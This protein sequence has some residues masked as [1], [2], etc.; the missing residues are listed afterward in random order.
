MKISRRVAPAALLG[1]GILSACTVTA[2]RVGHSSETLDSVRN[3]TLVH[4]SCAG[5]RECVAIGD[6]SG[7]PVILEQGARSTRILPVPSAFNGL[8][9]LACSG[10]GNC[11]TSLDSGNGS[12]RIEAESRG[13]WGSLWKN[14]LGRNLEA[15]QTSCS[16]GGSCWTIVT[17][18]TTQ[19]PP[20][21][22][23]YA[24]GEDGGRFL[25][26]VR[27]GVLTAS[28]ART[29]VS[30]APPTLSCSS[31]RS[32]T[33]L[34]MESSLVGGVRLTVVYTQRE[35]QNHW[36]DATVIKVPP[37]F[38]VA[39]GTLA[40]SA[41]ETCV[42]GGWEASAGDRVVSGA[43]L[44][45][46]RG[47]WRVSIST[48]GHVVD[49]GRFLITD[50]S[51]DS[52]GM[53]VVGGIARQEGNGK[54]D[55]F[56]QEWNGSGWEPPFASQV[57]AFW[58]SP[59]VAVSSAS[60]QLGSKCLVVGYA[61]DSFGVIRGFEIGYVRGRWQH[62]VIS[63]IAH[64]YSTFI[65]AVSCSSSYCGIAGFASMSGSMRFGVLADAAFG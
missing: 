7:K 44:L 3:L 61:P 27:L 49:G 64:S 22:T 24:I 40:C 11:V 48:S 6:I 25:P 34:G 12:I 1:A 26:A 52:S 54:E 42:A 30:I 29:M 23:T 58:G 45:E 57:N 60:C 39:S 65:K 46:R 63:W 28:R 32:C 14:S 2:V 13:S 37:S 43:V 62:V 19:G 5:N 31:M 56:A 10:Q 15:S 36:L 8:A 53:C 18:F 21:W 38:T 9:T 41:P 17:Q 47:Q 59:K 20:R 16:S 35:L 51:C 55:V 33:A 50:S 4:I